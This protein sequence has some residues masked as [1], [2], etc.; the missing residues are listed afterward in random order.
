M[1]LVTSGGQLGGAK[2][3]I[4]EPHKD[5]TGELYIPIHYNFTIG[6]GPSLDENSA[7]VKPFRY[8]LN[9]GKPPDEISF[10][11]HQENENDYF[12]LEIGYYSSQ[13]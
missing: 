2:I 9:D 13:V 12:V 11:F 7:L 4:R 1:F 6:R 8:I 10:V 5:S 3:S